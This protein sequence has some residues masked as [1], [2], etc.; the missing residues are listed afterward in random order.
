M[1]SGLRWKVG[2]GISVE[3]MLFLVCVLFLHLYYVHMAAD[4]SYLGSQEG[5]RVGPGSTGWELGLCLL[6][7]VCVGMTLPYE[8]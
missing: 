3:E 8:V 6:V 7:C 4:G 5:S 2:V 1:A